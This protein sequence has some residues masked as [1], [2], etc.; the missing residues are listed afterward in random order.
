MKLQVIENK[1][2]RVLT[3]EQ[4]AQVYETDINNIQANFTRNSKRFIEGKHYYKLEGE[5]LKDFKNQPTTSQL[6]SKHTSQLYLW[7]E[8]GTNRHCKIL[9]TD[10]AWDQFDNLEE[11][12]FRAK[13]QKKLSPMEELGLH[14]Q[15]IATHEEKITEIDNRIGSLENNMVLDFGQT[16]TIKKLVDKRIRKVLGD[17]YSDMKVRSKAYRSLWRDY[18]GY[19]DITSYHNTLKKDFNTAMELTKNWNPAGELLREVHYAKNQMSIQG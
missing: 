9:D 15:V 1:N 4:L 6:V 16:T 3:T 19:F 14:Y 10:K 2:Q 12:Y 18:K 5:E 11:V 17:A 7:T 13:D 8:R